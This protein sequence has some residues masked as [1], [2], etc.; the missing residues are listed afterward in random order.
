MNSA[1][2]LSIMNPT[3]TSAPQHE[4]LCQAEN[5]WSTKKE[6]KRGHTRVSFDSSRYE[7]HEIC[8]VDDIENKFDIWFTKCEY[9]EIRIMNKETVKLLKH[10]FLERLE[11]CYRGL[12]YKLSGRARNRRIQEAV[13]IIFI[14]QEGDHDEMALR[15]AAHSR[16][17]LTDAH[18]MGMADAKAARE[19]LFPRKAMDI[20]PRCPRRAPSA[21]AC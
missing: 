2:T 20:P 7:E 13:D 1:D 21:R 11:F 10:G 16:F 8:H 12:E 9:Q 3:N 17:C 5:T 14:Y 19:I 6:M 4:K 15:Y 18:E